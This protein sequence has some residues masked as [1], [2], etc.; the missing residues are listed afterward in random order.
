[1]IGLKTFKNEKEV[2][3]Y[4]HSVIHSRPYHVWLFDVCIDKTGKVLKKQNIRRL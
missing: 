4:V 1:M 3:I 2:K